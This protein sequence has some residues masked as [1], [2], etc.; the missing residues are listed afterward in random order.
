MYKEVQTSVRTIA[1][2]ADEFEIKVGLHQRLV[3]SPLL[4]IIMM[5]VLS[6]RPWEMLYTDDLALIAESVELRMWLSWQKP[7]VKN[8]LK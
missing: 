2:L 4:F 3:V 6:R 1:G 7:L 8:G 5:D